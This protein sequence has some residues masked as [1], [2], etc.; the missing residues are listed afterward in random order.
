MNKN[1]VTGIALMLA[2]VS[3][4]Q[5]GINTSVPHASAELD[6]ASASR[7]LLVPR[8]TTAAIDALT[9]TGSEG[10]IVFDTVRKLFLGFDGT[11]WQVLGN[12]REPVAF[13]VWEVSGINNFGN[14]PFAASAIT[15][16]VSAS[17]A[18][19]SGLGVSPTASNNAWGG[20]GFNSTD[21]ASAI[22]NGDFATITILLPSDHVFS[23]DKISAINIRRSNTGPSSVQW[24]YSVNGGANYVNIGPAFAL[25]ITVAAG[26][27]IPEITLTSISDLQSLSGTTVLFRIV[28]YG[29]TGGTGYINNIIGHDLEIIGTYD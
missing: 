1:I 14:S 13:A 27:Y 5:V 23:F 6:V 12:A 26:N 22:A 8:L 2:N 10:L 17:L 21:L 15:Q 7:G 18:R 16:I 20:I 19:G 25:P 29:G 9:E 28:G 3:I 4:A 24:Q 11:R